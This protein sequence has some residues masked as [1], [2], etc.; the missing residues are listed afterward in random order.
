MEAI[1]K[2]RWMIGAWVL[3]NALILPAMGPT[4]PPEASAAMAKTCSP[5]VR[6][7][8]GDYYRSQVRIVTGAVTCGEARSLLWAGLDWTL[9]THRNG[10]ECHPVN[11]GSRGLQ[12]Q[13]CNRSSPQT[14]ER[15]VVK[16]SRPRS[17]PSCTANKE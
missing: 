1:R 7:T 13:K 17:C 15:E 6:K 2:W 10:W 3:A 5:I 4:A 14:G 16:S 8:E 9:V 11:F 12:A